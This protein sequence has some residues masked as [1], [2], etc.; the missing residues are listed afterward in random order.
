MGE[1]KN[2]RVPIQKMDGSVEKQFFQ[3]RWESTVYV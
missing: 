3:K 1:E 2:I